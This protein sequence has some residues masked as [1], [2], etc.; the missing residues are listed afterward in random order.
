MEGQAEA[1]TPLSEVDRYLEVVVARC[2]LADRRSLDGLP[3]RPHCIEEARVDIA[4]CNGV[5]R[6]GGQRD[7]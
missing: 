7:G 3:A 6:D 5:A 4:D 2:R 1:R